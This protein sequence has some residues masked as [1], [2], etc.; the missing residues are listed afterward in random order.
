M[1]PIDW[2]PPAINPASDGGGLIFTNTLNPAIN[3]F[4]R[5]RSVP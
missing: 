5:I 1:P 3:S 4:W 2:L